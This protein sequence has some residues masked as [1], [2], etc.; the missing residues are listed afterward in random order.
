MTNSQPLSRLSPQNLEIVRALRFGRADSKAS[1]AV[2]TGLSPSTVTS[3]VQDLLTLGHI[4]ETG[5]GESRGGR[6]PRRLAIRAEAGAVGCFDLGIDRSS[7]GLVDF[8]GALL[9][10]AEIPLD[11]AAGPAPVFDTLWAALGDLAAGHSER[12]IPP[13]RALSLGVPGPVAADGNR[14]V[15]PSRMPGWNGIDAAAMLGGVAGLPVVV[16]NDANLMAVGEYAAGDRAEGNLVFVKAGSGIGSGIICRGELFVGADGV[17]G[18]ISHVSVPDAPPVA[19]S[20]GRRGCL[21]ALASGNALVKELQE[22]GEDV[23]DVESMIRRA[24]DADA[25]ATRLLRGAGTMTGG[26]LSTII[27]FFNPDRLVLG[28]VLSQSEVFVNAVR[29]TLYAECLP[30]ATE[31]LT[32]ALPR[33][34]QTSGL[35]GGGAVVL[36]RI[37]GP[38][39]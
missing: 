15:S 12:A 4:V 30:M 36:D 32:I 8:S 26:V 24:R 28:G 38:G 3:R 29:A 22:A 17:A 20:C 25:A 10:H 39:L 1:L 16:N 21:D 14:I 27:N 23:P 34:P 19:C 13:V 18:D 5:D 9:A 11:V 2:A 33:H 35:L 7:V 6:R 37:F 31:R